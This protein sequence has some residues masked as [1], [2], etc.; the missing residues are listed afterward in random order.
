MLYIIYLIFTS[1]YCSTFQRLAARG[2]HH[3]D[4]DKYNVIDGARS[5]N[6]QA[7]FTMKGPNPT[8]EQNFI[9]SNKV[10]NTSYTSLN[11]S[12]I[13][14]KESDSSK[15][16][17]SPKPTTPLPYKDLSQD[18]T[19]PQ[20]S[21]VAKISNEDMLLCPKCS[22]GFTKMQ[23]PEFLEHFEDCCDWHCKKSE[24][25]NRLQAPCLTLQRNC[26]QHAIPVG[27]LPS[28]PQRF[29][30]IY[31]SII[32]NHRNVE[33]VILMGCWESYSEFQL[34]VFSHVIAILK[35]C[36]IKSKSCDISNTVIERKSDF[37][38]NVGG[39]CAV[40]LIWGCSVCW[41]VPGL[42]FNDLMSGLFYRRAI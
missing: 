11:A 18:G 26:R 12:S 37:R 1:E 38:K 17:L 28:M 15:D 5:P 30:W 4:L 3:K 25:T 7:E 39:C 10:D 20:N 36:Y 14:S 19:S 34:C 8:L 6:P 16:R 40:E 22:K 35:D 2:V 42:G 29:R 13:S 21:P 41:R 33:K 24:T 9:A 31:K 23:H 32:I 27:P